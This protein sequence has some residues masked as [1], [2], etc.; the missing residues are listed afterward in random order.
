MKIVADDKIPFLKGALE[1]FAE[2]VYLPAN[3]INLEILKEA[4]ALLTRTRTKCNSNL[5]EGTSVKFIGTA[6]IGF[7]HIDTQYC[8]K[9]NIRWT[10][11]PGCNSSSV[12]QYIA[13][14]LLKIS[15]EFH[16]NLKDKTLGIIG[17]GNV[18][19]KVEMFARRMGMNVLLND[20]P[21][22][23]SEGIKNFHSLNKV[24]SSSDIVTVHVPL[25]I[26][27]EDTTYHLF[28]EEIFGRFKQGAWFF[29][30]SRGEVT[31][32]NA[33]KKM[34]YAGKLDGAV[35][36]VWENEPDID[37]EL[38]RQAYFATPHIAGYSTDGK[39]NGTAMVVN[40]LCR[41]F[42]LP[43]RNWYPLNIPLPVSPYISI[44]CN[45]KQEEEIL[46]EAVIHTYNIDEDSTRLRLSPPD[47][48]K[49]R[50]DY[51][52]RREFSAYT[53]DLKGGTEKVR[54][55]LNELGF[56]IFI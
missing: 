13:A 49:L 22:A 7:D 29:N 25:S 45:N 18:G 42:N 24:L 44:D 21:R 47:F 38:M 17:V 50:G 53:A 55:I 48:E 2:V 41:N 30:S 56:R 40:S 26:A 5:L 39:A 3:L 51:P 16:F 12:Q 8:K 36:D 54:Q 11:A 20:P 46:R 32:T 37:V 14:A 35:I 6:T 9:K 23:R 15:S 43:L 52:I 4:D 19:S 33:L 10:N 1:P 31:D 34:L 28:N 27:G